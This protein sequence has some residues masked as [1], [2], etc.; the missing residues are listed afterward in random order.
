V[1]G[2]AIALKT[3]PDYDEQGIIENS[4]GKHIAEAWRERLF[5]AN[6]K[7]T[8]G[9]PPVGEEHPPAGN[10]PDPHRGTRRGK[11][12]LQQGIR[13]HVWEPGPESEERAEAEEQRGNR[14]MP[15]E[16]VRR[17]R[18]GIPTVD[19][20]TPSPPHDAGATAWAPARA[21]LPRGLVRIPA[22]S[23]AHLDEGGAITTS[24]LVGKPAVFGIR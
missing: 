16:A 4:V 22:P 2:Q 3:G 11:L 24:V 21:T 6:A 23:P 7:A 18:L 15:I 5:N 20:A 9:V 10:A 14:R 13:E 17:A 1:V 12:G 19:I 8:T